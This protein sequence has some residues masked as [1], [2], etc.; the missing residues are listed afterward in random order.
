ME[1]INKTI[2]IV[3]DVYDSTALLEAYLKPYN[4]NLLYANDGQEAVDI[5]KNNNIDL[6]LMDIKMPFMGGMEATELIK[7]NKPDLPIIA[8]TAYALKGDKEKIMLSGCDDYISK[9]INK[10]LLMKKIFKALNLEFVDE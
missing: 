6:V 7:K 8:Q 4:F 3:E 2:L 1:K 5:C 9:P 10:S